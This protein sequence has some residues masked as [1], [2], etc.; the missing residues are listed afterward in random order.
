[1]IHEMAI[2]KLELE[3]QNEELLQAREELKEGLERFTRLYDFSP[4]GYVTLAYD[5][6]IIEINLTGA[7]ILGVERSLL[8]GDRFGR[9]ITQNDLTIFNALLDRVFKLKKPGSC[10]VALM[11]CNASQREKEVDGAIPDQDSVKPRSLRIKAVAS[12]DG[13]ECLMVFLH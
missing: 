1:M 6:T 13:Q 3:M 4:A 9:F 11:N 12:E 5:S 10:E 8:A 7:K 2:Q